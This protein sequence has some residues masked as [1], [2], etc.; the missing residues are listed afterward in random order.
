MCSSVIILGGP[1]IVDKVD[2]FALSE[3]NE[4]HFSSTQQHFSAGVRKVNILISSHNHS[5]G[6]DGWSRLTASA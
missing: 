5:A 1:F 4:Q 2:N 6:T 3:Y